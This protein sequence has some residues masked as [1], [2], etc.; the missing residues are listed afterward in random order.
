MSVKWSSARTHRN[1][2]QENFLLSFNNWYCYP[3]HVTIGVKCLAILLLR[4][5]SWRPSGFSVNNACNS[6]SSRF[7][8]I[9]HLLAFTSSHS[10]RYRNYLQFCGRGFSA[11]LLLFASFLKRFGLS[12]SQPRSTTVSLSDHEN[13]SLGLMAP[14]GFCL[15][16]YL[17]R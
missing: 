5:W 17:C 8:P 10:R 14:H 7:S 4:R 15:W 6:I 12:H 11:N 16:R 1:I 9:Q 3:T 13:V 2:H